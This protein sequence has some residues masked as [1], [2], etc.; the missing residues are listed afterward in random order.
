MVNGQGEPACQTL[1]WYSTCAWYKKKRQSQ[2]IIVL[3]LGPQ[4][5]VLSP[6]LPPSMLLNAH[7]DHRSTIHITVVVNNS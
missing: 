7:Q 4:L 2:P 6:L 3:N 5:V 1:Q